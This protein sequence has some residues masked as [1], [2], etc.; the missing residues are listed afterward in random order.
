MLIYIFKL[1]KIFNCIDN[2]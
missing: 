2:L 1:D